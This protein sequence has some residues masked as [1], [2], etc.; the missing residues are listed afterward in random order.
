MSRDKYLTEL[1]GYL[2]VLP[3]ELKTKILD[4]YSEYTSRLE[5]EGEDLVDKLGTPRELADNILDLEFNQGS[6][7]NY[8]IPKKKKKRNPLK[9]LVIIFVLLSIV[10]TVFLLFAIFIKSTG[11]TIYW[12][13]DSHHFILTSDLT[14]C[15]LEK[16]K[17]E[18]FDRIEI[19]SHYA[20]VIFSPSD[21][22][23][24]EYDVSADSDTPY[25][26]KDGTLYFSDNTH[27]G[28][29]FNF[30]DNKKDEYITIY[31][32]KNASFEMI[33]AELDM[34]SI[35]IADIAIQSLDLDM[36]M[37]SLSIDN[38]SVDNLS[39]NLD[40]GSAIIM[41]CTIGN[42]DFELDMGNL[43]MTATYISGSMTADLDMGSADIELISKGQNRGYYG[44]DLSC[45]IGSV[46]LNNTDHGKEY[47]ASG[48]PIINISCDLG[49]ISV[50][51]D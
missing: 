8:D 37:G 28:I 26:I 40:M 29:N 14:H 22:Y 2:S 19:D 45:D 11:R 13:K 16:T 24:I 38:C 41:D 36:D 7:S 9:P 5:A 35:Y 42:A 6:H 44:L 32:P 31:Y 17:I 23:Y 50:D 39:S 1:G 48:S 25:F 46:R 21:D 20:T 49:S 43:D 18:R 12:D 27:F 4:F 34:G 47:H 51:I 15:T 30:N 33:T 10:F 3:Q